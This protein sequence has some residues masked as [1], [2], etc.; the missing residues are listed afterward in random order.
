[1]FKSKIKKSYFI[2]QGC[3]KV[4]IISNKCCSFELSVD[5]K[6]I[7]DSTINIKHNCFLHW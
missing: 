5:Q 1:M 4:T 6:F 2:Q 3:T 7:T